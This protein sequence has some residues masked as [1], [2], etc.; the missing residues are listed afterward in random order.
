MSWGLYNPNT[1]AIL[2]LR[3]LVGLHLSDLMMVCVQQIQSKCMHARLHFLLQ[4]C[5][6]LGKDRTRTGCA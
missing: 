6:G 4:Y 1:P 3:H 2:Y 5:M